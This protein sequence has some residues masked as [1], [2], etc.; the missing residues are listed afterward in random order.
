MEDVVFVHVLNGVQGLDEKLKGLQLRKG[1]VVGLEVEQ[2]AFSSVLHDQ[3][4][5][6]G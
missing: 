5:A 4:D 6:F 1:F 3:V 2:I